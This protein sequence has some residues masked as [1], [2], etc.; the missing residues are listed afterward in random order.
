MKFNSVVTASSVVAG[1]G[2]AAA[3]FAIGTAI[4]PGVGSVIGAVVGGIS[5]GIAGE[6]I[7]AKAYK[8]I[9]QRIDQSNQRKKEREMIEFVQ[10]FDDCCRIDFERFEEAMAILGVHNYEVS[11]TDVEK[12][13]LA[14]MDII[15]IN[16]TNE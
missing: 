12:S 3:G 16:K 4:F 10:S 8:S 9:E 6:K 11:I 13:Y 15:T 2:G 14:M 5:A 1:S 7:S